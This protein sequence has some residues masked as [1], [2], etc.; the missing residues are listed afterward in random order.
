MA[1]PQTVIPTKADEILALVAA[2]H[3]KCVKE[4]SGLMKKVFEHQRRE[5]EE[6]EE[7]LKELG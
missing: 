7:L 6:I 4:L 2:R 1:A 5:L 3:Q